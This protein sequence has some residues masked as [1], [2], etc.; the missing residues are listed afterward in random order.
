MQKQVFLF[1]IYIKSRLYSERK[2][3]GVLGRA[4][5]MFYLHFEVTLSNFVLKLKM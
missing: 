5:E 2:G 4:Q 1:L 3:G